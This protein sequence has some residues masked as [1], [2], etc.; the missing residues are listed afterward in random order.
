MLSKTR[1]N[2]GGIVHIS[3]SNGNAEAIS[4]AKAKWVCHTREVLGGN[5]RCDRLC[6]D[7]E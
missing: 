2:E 4:V 3:T 7:V 5:G 1:S 6:L